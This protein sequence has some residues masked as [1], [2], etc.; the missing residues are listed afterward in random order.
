[1]VRETASGVMT[2]FAVGDIALRMTPMLRCVVLLFIT[3]LFITNAIA[4]DSPLPLTESAKRMTL[5]DGFR[6][7]LFAGEPDLVQPMAFDIDD[8]GRLW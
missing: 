2:H 5:P 1:M 6:A 3:S 4:Q 7:T 8:R